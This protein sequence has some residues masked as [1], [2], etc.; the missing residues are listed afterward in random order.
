[1]PV[2][3]FVQL[4]ILTLHLTS[5]I[6]PPPPPPPPGSAGPSV[7]AASTRYKHI[8]VLQAPGLKHIAPKLEE[9]RLVRDP[10]RA[11]LRFSSVDAIGAHLAQ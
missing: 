8:S 6:P 9:I 5:A 2:L 4:Q 3:V 7:P 1:M 10:V 11:Y